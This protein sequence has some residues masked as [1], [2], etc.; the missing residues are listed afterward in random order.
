M[1]D[2]PLPRQV[3]TDMIMGEN[4]VTAEESDIELP[5]GVGKPGGGEGGHAAPG[6]HR[7]FRTE[8]SKGEVSSIIW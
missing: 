1:T 6:F 2:C 8:V 3:V 5:G 7:S 4:H